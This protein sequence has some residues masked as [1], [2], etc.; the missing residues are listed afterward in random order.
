MRRM[1]TE[2][3]RWRR[4]FALAATLALTVAN[5]LALAATSG[6]GAGNAMEAAAK[7]P[8]APVPLAVALRTDWPD[9]GPEAVR[10]AVEDELQSWVVSVDPAAPVPPYAARLAVDVSAARGEIAVRYDG[11]G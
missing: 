4:G 6:E 10:R 3:P 7:P 9:L 8:A 2:R 5:G 1:A 11:P